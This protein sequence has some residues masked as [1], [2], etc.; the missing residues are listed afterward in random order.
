MKTVTVTMN[1]EQ[2][3]A[4]IAALT[5]MSMNN[6]DFARTISGPPSAYALR[7]AQNASDVI[8]LVHTQLKNG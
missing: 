6:L 7:R 4:V 3:R 1:E 5:A 2:A 8:G